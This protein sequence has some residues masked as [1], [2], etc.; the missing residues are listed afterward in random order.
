MGY[1]NENRNTAK[2]VS[3]EVTNAQDVRRKLARQTAE[4][5]AELARFRRQLLESDTTPVDKPRLRKGF[6]GLWK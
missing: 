4:L 1:S 5:E 2:D 6:F 3:Q